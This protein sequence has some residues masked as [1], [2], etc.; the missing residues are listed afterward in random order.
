[1]ERFEAASLDYARAFGIERDQDWFILKL[2]E[3]LGELTQAWNRY[4]GR[5][6]VGNVEDDSLHKSLEDEAADVLGHVLLLAHRYNLDLEAA[7]QRK[8]RFQVPPAGRAR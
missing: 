2:Q 1:M 5:G 6:R 3:E 8:W 7:V 4:S